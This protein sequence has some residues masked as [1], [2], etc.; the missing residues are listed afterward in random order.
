[1]AVEDIRHRRQSHPT[2]PP[3]SPS[4]SSRERRTMTATDSDDEHDDVLE[5]TPVLPAP[6]MQL[7]IHQ[8]N[9]PRVSCAV[10][11]SITTGGTTYAF[12]L[13]GDALK[14]SLH[15]TQS[16]LDTISAVFFLSGLL[17]FIPGGFADRFGTR[18]GIS[19]GGVTG[20]VS[21]LSF[22]AVAKGWIP[23][24]SGDPSVAVL[25]LS[26]LSVGIFLSCALVTGSVFK[27]ISCQC[28]AGSKGSA[29]GVAKGFVGLGSG[30][31]ACIFESIRQ[32]GWSELEFLPLCAFFFVFCASIPSFLILP[33]KENETAVPDVLTPLHFRLIYGS[34]IVLASLIII[35][36]MSELHEDDKKGDNTEEPRSNIFMAVLVLIAWLGPIIAWWVITQ[37]TDY[38]P[39]V[40]SDRIAPEQ[41]EDDSAEQE[42]LLHNN[43]NGTTAANEDKKGLLRHGEGN[44]GTEGDIA[45]EP[46]TSSS[47]ESTPDEEFT[48]EDDEESG[49]VVGPTTSS[50]KNLM[51]MLSTPS[52]WLMLWTGTMLAGGG[53]VETNN[54][55]QMVESL[56][57]SKGVVPAT[58]ALFSVAQSGGR[59]ITGAISESAL[60]YNTGS[61]CIDSGIPRPFWF[62]VASI[63]AVLAHTMLAVATEEVVFVVG[64]TL[65]GVAFGMIWPLM[66]LCV[67]EI[68]GT[69][70]VGANYMFYDGFT[71]AAG[72]FLLS[73]IVAQEVYE[74]HIDP[75]SSEGNTTCIGKACFRETHVV[76]VFVSLTCILTSIMLQ[77]KTRDVYNKARL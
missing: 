23:L 67:G 37:K 16:Q 4:S 19:I 56:G 62:V 59:V 72:T 49:H 9:V 66:V 38:N 57:Y 10:L 74:E 76:V 53:T 21:L 43:E 39:L 61:C 5:H 75:H 63:A 18:L 20:A 40:S 28:G 58:L 29:V 27:I 35:N 44:D 14:K 55:G 30:A 6:Q 1:M 77:W 45:M 31:Y 42:T 24:L 47:E 11:A 2:S 48:D 26:T 36:A 54:L 60:A 12:G 68:Y 3:A 64:V 13:Y 33:R 71:S 51:Q 50:D 34:L 52:A 22:W 41:E 25:V 73:K 70:H 69:A 7:P 15:L 17:S 65:C 32:P 46:I 8:T